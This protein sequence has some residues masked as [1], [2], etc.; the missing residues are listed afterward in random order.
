MNAFKYDY[1]ATSDKRKFFPFVVFRSS[2]IDK[3]ITQFVNKKTKQVSMRVQQTIHFS[4]AQTRRHREGQ[5][6]VV[7]VRMESDTRGGVSGVGGCQYAEE[8][9]EQ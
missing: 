3:E 4:E 7:S 8:D 1:S 6:E 2:L 5:G 9:L